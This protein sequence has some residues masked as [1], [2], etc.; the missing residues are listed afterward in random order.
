VTST[1]TD[2]AA[3]PKKVFPEER[4][5]LK[6]LVADDHVQMRALLALRLREAGY[7]VVEVGD[8]AIAWTELHDGLRDDDNPRDVD[9]FVSDIQ[10]PGRSGLEV[11]RMLRGARE[12]LPVILMTAFGDAATHAEARRLGAVR[13]F[14]KPFNITDLVA[15]ALHLLTP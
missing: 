14:D 4:P 12:H 11:L 1:N 10:M 3:P 9:L 6:V 5:L 15:L 2:D 7:D 8:G 13:V